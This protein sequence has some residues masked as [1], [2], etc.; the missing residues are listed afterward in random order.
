MLKFD[1]RGLLKAAW[2]MPVC[3]GFSSQLFI[4]ADAAEPKMESVTPSAISLGET[5]T[6]TIIGEG[7]QSIKDIVFYNQGIKC[8]EVV[9][10]GDFEAT[11]KIQ[12]DVAAA[13]GSAPFRLLTSDGFSNVKTLRL[14]D[15]PVMVEPKRDTD[16]AEI[17]LQHDA[18]V[19]IYG[20]LEDGQYDRYALELEAGETITAVVDAVRL[21]GNLLDTVLKVYGPSG[22]L[23]TFV[24]D[25][26]LYRQDPYLQFSAPGPGRYVLE[27]H[28]TNY[29]GSDD[30][31]YLLYVGNLPTPSILYPPGGQ[32][33]QPLNVVT[34][35]ETNNASP[36]TSYKIAP[37]EATN[38][39][40]FNYRPEKAGKQAPTAVRMR[41]SSF[42]NVIEV[43]E[44]NDFKSVL[45]TTHPV[46]AAFCGIIESDGDVDCFA[47]EAEAGAA[48]RF[49]SFSERIGAPLDTLISIVDSEG[50][51]LV[52][53]DDWM[54]HDSRLDFKAPESGTDVL[55]VTDKLGNGFPHGVYRV[56]ASG[57]SPSVTSF[58]PRPDRTSQ[59]GQSIAVPQGNRALVNVAVRRELIEG[60]ADLSFSHLP[61]GVHVSPYSIPAD[62]YWM[63]SIITASDTA[64]I[65]G[66]LSQV[67]VRIGS[68]DAQVSGGFE[69]AIDL[70]AG[71]A[72]TLF[73]GV[74]LHRVP[75]AVVE[76][77]PFTIEL[78]T[79]KTSLAVG[80]TIK[81][82]VRV[83]RDVGFDEP[84]I[85]RFPFLPSW[86]TCEPEANIPAGVDE[87]EHELVAYLEAEH[88]TWP[89]VVTAEVDVKNASSDVGQLRGKQ[90]ASELVNLTIAAAPIK[91]QFAPIAAEQGQTIQ[92]TCKCIVDGPLPST[93]LAT[94]EGL[95]NRVSCDPVPFQAESG[96]VVFSLKLADDAPVGVFTSLSC[97]LRGEL[98]QQAVTYVVAH[99][100]ALQ[101]A[102]PGKLVRGTSGELLSPLEAL[103]L[104]KSRP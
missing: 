87:V 10:D 104:K 52:S 15:L 101:I 78:E 19:A 13:V 88:R 44:N 1:F 74:N 37:L 32:V 39:G 80:G 59:I 2:L 82:K 12:V 18:S 66:N 20:T 85:V 79:P 50:N 9:A 90:V 42:P 95:P 25:T 71:S 48:F 72:D 30:S 31:H 43:G 69:Q 81:L 26:A 89:L 53:G 45:T 49:E 33:G 11:A 77:V 51:L 36:P 63:P 55:V 62:R 93:M 54:C 61:A 7:L 91:G 24:D 58:L 97:R 27:I 28:E 86:V 40:W 8:L 46:P 22:D 60:S 83:M 34:V 99:N 65:G 70:V 96:E 47:F 5:R 57:I 64:T 73:Y 6:V 98:K 84:I 21:G 56:E 68:G 4:A 17:E 3:I 102:E 23:I 29:N 67:D 35:P 103:K 92:V 76:P 14:T 16:N 75:V 100:T 94:L 38:D 41:V